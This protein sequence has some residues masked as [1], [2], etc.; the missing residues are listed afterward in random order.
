MKVIL[1]CVYKCVCVCVCVCDISLMEF[2][3]KS[4]Y[5]YDTCMKVLAYLSKLVYII[6]ETPSV[7]RTVCV[8][9]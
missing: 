9:I 7:I 8:L 6:L 2:K 1:R 3:H 4:G 5:E